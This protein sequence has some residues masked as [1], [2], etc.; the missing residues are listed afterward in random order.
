[1]PTVERDPLYRHSGVAL[2]RAA[3]VPLASTP[4]EWPDLADTESC[5]AWLSTIWAIPA[6]ASAVRHASPGLADRVGLIRAGRTVPD[7]QVRRA[8]A[9]IVRYLLRAV[10]RPT[11]FGLFAG[12]APVELGAV[13]RV[14]WGHDHRPATRVDTQ[15]LAAIIERLEACPELMERLAVVFNNLATQRGG[16]LE[17]PAGPNRVRKQHTSAIRLVRDAAVHPI[18]FGDLA[19]KLS[20]AFPDVGDSKIQD[21][22]TELVQQGFLI[23]SLRAPLTTTDPLGYLIDRLRE[24]QAETLPQAA[25]LSSGLEA[26]RA[27][28]QRLNESAGNTQARARA[29]TTR[30]MRRLAP[31][32]RTQLSVDLRLDCDVHLPEEI[33]E[34]MARA[35]DVLLRLTRD[36]AG[37]A[38][39]RD[40]QGRFC[41]RYGTGTLVPL[42]DVVNPDA[43][44][45]YPASYPGSVLPVPAEGPAERDERLL[46]LAWRAIADSS[47]EIVLTEELIAS[48]TGGHLDERSIPPHV[49]IAA[50]IHAADID[51]LL[52]GEYSLTVSPARSAG[53]LTSRFSPLSTG[54]GLE[55]AYRAVPTGIDGALPVQLSF[56]PVYPHAENVSRIPRY[57][58]H[59]LS[60]SEHRGPAEEGTVIPL[61]DL[62]IT[63]TRDRLH[64]VS[65]SRRRVIEPQVFHA[66]A[67]EKQPPPLARFLAQLPR[68]FGPRW[69]EFDW[70][71]HAH[72]L[73]YLPRIRYGRTV[74]CPARW[75]LTADDLLPQDA[76]SEEQRQALEQWRTRWH[77]PSTVELRDADRTLRT[78]RSSP[79][80]WTAPVRGP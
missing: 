77:C 78:P 36:P 60:L 11:P 22:I 46:T 49:E 63:A 67:L 75:R 19:G 70:G 48:L 45:G 64:L 72:R 4:Y 8:T 29:A 21:L 31:A 9:S 34:E 47:H 38:V 37:D 39:W 69:H 66:L 1:M 17:V 23:T 33:A 80:T 58:P 68:A 74:I 42:T 61:D 16:Q 27:D 73:P 40:Y 6:F 12:V 3:A 2:I 59:V 5:R 41:D 14:R 55:R 51:A 10:G 13:A 26:I 7:K 62:A 79:T 44:L 50:R 20:D 24:A 32:G 71:P 52:H 28:V 65:V 30:A 56:P 43:G 57:L 53:T 35:A 76:R 25:P 54:S 15:W 18:G